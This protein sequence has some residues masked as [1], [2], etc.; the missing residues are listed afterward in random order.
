MHGF[1]ERSVAVRGG[2]TAR[3]EARRYLLERVTSLDL[4]MAPSADIARRTRSRRGSLGSQALEP[5]SVHGFE[6]QLILKSLCRSGREIAGR[7]ERAIPLEACAVALEAQPA[8]LVGA[9]PY[10]PAVPQCGSFERPATRRAKRLGASALQFT[11]RKG[12]PFICGGFCE[13]LAHEP[14]R[15]PRL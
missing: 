11:A 8:S 13:L 6:R 3:L 12:N 1:E 10:C 7:V 2:K 9:A 5:Y 15:N 4:G 14:Q